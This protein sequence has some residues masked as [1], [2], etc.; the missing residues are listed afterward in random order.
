MAAAERLLP[1]SEVMARVGKRRSAIYARMAA[2]TF[3][4]P[5]KDPDTSAVLWVESEVAAWIAEA[6]ETWPRG[7]T[8]VGRADDANKKAA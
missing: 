3:P 7:G 8:V 1:L 6:V 2:G 5:I 4:L